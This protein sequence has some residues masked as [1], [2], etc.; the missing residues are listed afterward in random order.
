MGVNEF[1]YGAGGSLTAFF[2]DIL[3]QHNV[4][5]TFQ[6]GGGSGT[7]G[8]AEQLGGALFYI[9][10]TR[11]LNWG[12]EVQH[13]PYVTG[14]VGFQRGFVEVDGQEVFADIYT[15]FREI[16]MITDASAL[17]QYPFSTT[18]RIEASIGGQRYS[19]KRESETFIVVNDQ[20]IDRRDE[21]LPGGFTLNF[22]KGSTAFVGDSS[23]F[24]FI[25]PINGTRYRY[26]IE[27][28]RGDLN[29]QT[30]L[31][32]WRKYFFM[33]PVTV[34]VRGMHYGRYGNGADDPRLSPLYL[35]QG[36]L[37]R[38]YDPYSIDPTECGTNPAACPVFDRLVGTRLAAASL[39]VRAP[40]FG[41]REF[42]IFDAPFLPTEIFA[43]GDVGA[44]WSADESVNW[45]Y[46][47]R[48]AERVPV[49]SVGVGLRI[50][51]SYIPI[52]VFAAKPFHR[53]DED[54][55]YGFNIIP[56]W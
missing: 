43:F 23:V 44:A 53:P 22:S 49:V 52:E 9:N 41:T 4:G 27:A 35:G 8:L 36:S 21:S 7:S 16:Q 46:E 42:G 31:A 55:V 34:A 20:V 56:G 37:L 3:G 32:D 29:F 13:T 28:L 54:I 19:Y 48:T 26:E 2:S 14:A 11:R 51:L 45:K 12:A 10:Q 6:G 33:R 47:T 18:R 39:E 24:G 40:L 15:E 25:S 1:G 5:F 30:A 50:L 38:G 17:A